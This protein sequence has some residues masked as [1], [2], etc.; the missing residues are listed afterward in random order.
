MTKKSILVTVRQDDHQA[1]KERRDALDVRW[2]ALL[3]AAD[4]C[5][6]LIPNDLDLCLSLLENCRYDG[7]L[8]TGG[9]SLRQYGGDA[10]ARDE[11]EK[12]LINLAIEKSLPVL[13]VCR[14]MQ[15]MLD[16]FNCD[17]IPVEGHVAT[18]HSIQ[19]QESGLLSDYIREIT[20]VNSYHT[21]SLKSPGPFK[22]I[23]ST[24]DG[25]IEAIEHPDHK[26]FG[27]MWHP[28]REYVDLHNHIKMLKKVFVESD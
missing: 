16:K 14:G 2:Y 13:G 4:L 23:A 6:I 18:R 17:L 15:L 11:I 8:L 20:D 12:M 19:C 24:T 5:P 3:K 26:L 21:F 25:L 10:A 1:Y 27:I 28:E 9:N 7:V 22:P